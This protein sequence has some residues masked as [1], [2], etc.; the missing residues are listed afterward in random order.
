MA[1]F[2]FTYGTNKNF[3]FRGG[4][5][6]ITAPDVSAACHIFRAVHPDKIDGILNCADIYSE[7][8]FRKTNMYLENNNFGIGCREKMTLNIKRFD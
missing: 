2:Y 3:P 7:E 1:N 4:W 5:T 6:E 8:S